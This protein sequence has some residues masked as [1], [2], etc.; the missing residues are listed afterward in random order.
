MCGKKTFITLGHTEGTVL[1]KSDSVECLYALNDESGTILTMASGEKI[2]TT[3]EINAV[4]EKM[5]EA[6]KLGGRIPPAN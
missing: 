1:V 6:E 3:D 5:R 4:I 2:Q